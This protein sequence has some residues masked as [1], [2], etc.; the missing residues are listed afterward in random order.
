MTGAKTAVER[1]A[2]VAPDLEA[3]RWEVGAQPPGARRCPLYRAWDVLIL[4]GELGYPALDV[5][6]PSS[7]GPARCLSTSV[8]PGWGSSCH[9]ARRP[10]GSA[11]ASAPPGLAPGSSCCTRA[12]PPAARPGLCHRTARASSPTPGSSSWPCTRRQDWRGRTGLA[13]FLRA[14]TSAEP[15]V[16]ARLRLR[17]GVRDRAGAGDDGPWELR[18]M[19]A[20]T[21]KATI[22]RYNKAL[23]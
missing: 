23:E 11:R 19:D 2:F 17:R 13:G 8:T 6:L 21:S 7:T 20:D 10:A 4:P 5:L 1:L 14:L 22:A 12:A 3:C 16:L 9:R 18:F 15:G